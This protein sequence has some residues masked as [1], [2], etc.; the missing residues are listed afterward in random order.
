M[1]LT[2]K[3]SLISFLLVLSSAYA[4]GTLKVG[5]IASLTG[6]NANQGRM[7]QAGLKLALDELN[8]KGGIAGQKLELLLEDDASDPATAQTAAEKLVDEGVSVVIGTHSGPVNR[9]LSAYFN[10]VKVPLIVASA[11]EETI[12]K[13]GNPF[14]F[15]LSNSGSVLTRAM[16]DQLRRV[17]NLKTAVI[18]GSNDTFGKGVQTEGAKSLLATGVKV[19]ANETYEKGTL[20]FLPV[21]TRFKTLNPDLVI[22]ASY[23]EDA[24]LLAKQARQV[25]LTPRVMVGLGNGFSQPE[26]LQEAGRAAE[27]FLTSANWNPD[28]KYTSAALL[29]QLLKRSLGGQEPSQA[30]AMNYAAMLVAADALKRGG[31]NPSK[32]QEALTKTK[33]N[34][35]IGAIS[36]RNFGGFQNQNS[37]IT[38]I[39]Q[40]QSG[41]FITVGPSS[42]ARTTLSYPRR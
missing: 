39:T 41:K 2:I 17:S 9:S 8:A 4:Q 34:T 19:V 32:V 28:V 15:R 31:A 40:V 16:L 42:V 13:P 5:A 1:R 24:T 23:E 22:L 36:F 18:L 10:S 30:A 37:V 14:T 3:L 21:L 38:L 12:T 11:S 20:D 6:P 29:Y 35:P 26:F 27:F 33:M 7:Q 25:G